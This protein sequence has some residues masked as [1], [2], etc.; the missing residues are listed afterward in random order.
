MDKDHPGPL[1]ISSLAL[2]GG[3]LYAGTLSRGLMVIDNGEAREVTTK[4]R[5]YFINALEVDSHGRLWT[6]G[7]ARA[8]E[9]GLFD[10]DDPLKPSKANAATGTVTAITRG[11]RDDIWVATDG[12]GAFHVAGGET[13]WPPHL[14]RTRRERRPGATIWLLL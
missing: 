13:S 11:S 4:P 3:K 12:R 8:D 9:G 6:G 14:S 5:N 1:K 10:N 7:R 2:V